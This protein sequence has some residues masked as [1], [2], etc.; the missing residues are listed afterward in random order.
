MKN[1]KGLHTYAVGGIN[2]FDFALGNAAKTNMITANASRV[3][4]A[5]SNKSES[6]D[7]GWPKKPTKWQKAQK[8]KRKKICHGTNVC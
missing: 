8:K 1:F 4:K 2:T 6:L 3:P 5:M 7:S